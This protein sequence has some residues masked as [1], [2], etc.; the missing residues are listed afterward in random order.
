MI[1][2]VELA[3]ALD[4]TNFSKENSFEVVLVG[5]IVVAIELVEMAVG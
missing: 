4:I 2:V 1:C 5:V 3:Y